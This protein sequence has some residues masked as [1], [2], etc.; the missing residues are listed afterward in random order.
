MK[1]ICAARHENRKGKTKMKKLL[2]MIGAAAVAVGANALTYTDGS[3][4]AW[5]F[6]ASGSNATLGDG[7]AACIAT[8][9]AVDAANIPWTFTYDDNDYTVTAIAA[10]AFKG[11][12]ELSGTLT[13][14]DAV[15]SIGE[16]AFSGCTKLTGL[17]SL[18][19]ITNVQ[20]TA[21][22][23]CSGLKYYPDLSRVTRI[24]KNTFQNCTMGGEAILTSLTSARDRAFHNA[25]ITNVVF[26]RNDAYLIGNYLFCNCTQLTGMYI[27]GPDSGSSKAEIRRNAFVQGCTALK[28]FL[29]GP[30]TELYKSYDSDASTTFTDVAGCRIFVP[31]D[32]NWHQLTNGTDYA[33]NNT[34]L[35]Y[36]AGRELDFS[37][38]HDTKAITAMP[39]TA[40]AFTNVLN[41]ASIFKSQFG[42]DTRIVM[43]NAIEVAEGT[44]TDALLSGV[45]FESLIFNVKTQA[46]L[47]MVMAA[48]AG[49]TTPLCIDPTGAK[50][51]MTVPA[52]RR[53]WVLLSGDG[54]YTPKINGTIITFY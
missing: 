8:G 13:I 26:N 51:Q 53:V 4:T 23:S 15:T 44:I 54:K 10:K 25:T 5:T 12:T 45:A 42:Y 16:S 39:A 2:M 22:Y 24:G 38:D 21:F 30:L 18:G 36:G 27:P 49:V 47:D 34:F 40:H 9:T 33:A 48:T 32:S 37:F 17:A 46:Q 7:S 50:Q 3:G 11:C 41:A 31:E 35:Y 52:D 29:A 6:T 43:T 20:D 1:T 28:V 19:G 14:P